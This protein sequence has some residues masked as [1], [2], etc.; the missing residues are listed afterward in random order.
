MIS[1]TVK[2]KFLW[3]LR[4]LATGI[5]LIYAAVFIFGFFQRFNGSSPISVDIESGIPDNPRFVIALA[6]VC[7]VSAAWIFRKTGKVI[8][9][10][11]SIALIAYQTWQWFDSTRHIKINAGLDR[12]PGSSGIGNV[13]IGA[14]TIDILALVGALCLLAF[15]FGRLGVKNAFGNHGFGDFNN[16]SRRELR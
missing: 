15:S 16:L 7:G 6:L 9:T 2:R 8:S 14:G 3:A 10:S 13:L 12:F 5:A 1:E 4:W 11:L